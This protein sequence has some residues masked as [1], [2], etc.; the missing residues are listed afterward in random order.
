LRRERERFEAAGL[1]VVLVG[2]GTAEESEAFR[3]R[4]GVPFPLIS[5]PGKKLYAAYGLQAGT[6]GD[7][8]SPTTLLRSLSAL[9]RGHLP[10]VPQGDVL[11]M[12]GA[13]VI[14]RDGT[15]LFAHYAR[16]AADH[17]EPEALRAAGREAAA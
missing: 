15:V 11:Q 3:Q 9:G 14:D 6:L 10:G 17:P 5:D 13:F 8:L 12:P 16:D 4:F 1:Q 7:V 2:M